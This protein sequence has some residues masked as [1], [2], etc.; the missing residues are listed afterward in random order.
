[1]AVTALTDADRRE[2]SRAHRIA[3]L[4][5]AAPMSAEALKAA[6]DAAIARYLAVAD[7]LKAEAGVKEHR[8]RDRLSGCA[9]FDRGVI[10]A[11]EGRPRKQLYILA[12]ECAHV[13]LHGAGRGNGKA[14]HVQEME[15]ERGP[16]RA[17][18]PRH[19]RAP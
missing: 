5:A 12:R 15:C 18:P 16:C 9:W 6:R 19:R 4:S 1:M 13:L 2:I 7:A 14:V 3:K 8:I 17:A 11:P 10:E